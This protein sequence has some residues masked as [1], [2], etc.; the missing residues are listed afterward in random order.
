MGAKIEEINVNWDDQEITFGGF[1]FTVV[2]KWSGE[3]KF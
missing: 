3:V 1:K 2:K